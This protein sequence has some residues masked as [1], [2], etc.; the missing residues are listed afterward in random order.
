M[1]IAYRRGAARTRKNQQQ[2]C[3]YSQ[4][5]STSVLAAAPPAARDQR[6]GIQRGCT[7]SDEIEFYWVFQQ[8]GPERGRGE[9]PG[10]PRPPARI[11]TSLTLARWWSVFPAPSFDAYSVRCGL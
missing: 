4:Y 2:P 7:G 5:T 8:P 10:K 9:L 6:P 1:K 11:P 3:Q